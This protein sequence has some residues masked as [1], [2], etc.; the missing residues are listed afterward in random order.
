MAASSSPRILN[1]TATATGGTGTYAI[2]NSDHSSSALTNV[3][4]TASGGSNS[5]LGV[6]NHTASA[7]MMNVTATGTGGSVLAVGVDNYA[8]SGSYTVKINN[9]KITGTSYSVASV[10]PYFTTLVSSSELV[11]GAAAG[12]TCAGVYNASYTFFASTCP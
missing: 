10:L 4:A 8:G 1:V 5:N 11:G 3:T 6:Y 12:A 2:M 9:S 7:T